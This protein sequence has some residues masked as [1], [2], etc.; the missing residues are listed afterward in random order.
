MSWFTQTQVCG[1]L[2]PE[3]LLIYLILTIS[4]LFS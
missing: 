2:H 1:D 3:I 4:R